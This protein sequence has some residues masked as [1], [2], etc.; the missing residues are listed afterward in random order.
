MVLA[1]LSPDIR[2]W[3]VDLREGLRAMLGDRLA[4]LRLFGSQVRGDAHEESDIDVLVLV[5]KLDNGTHR[6]ISELA[7][8][9][10][11]WFGLVIQDFERYHRP[12]S[13]AS[14]FYKSM[15]EESVRL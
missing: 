4:D 6:A 15:R 12:V 5:H 3:V 9:I 7:W 8:S 14:G 10:T 13:R 2:G 1:R 11:S